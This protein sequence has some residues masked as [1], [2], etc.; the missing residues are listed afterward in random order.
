[1][2]APLSQQGIGLAAV[3]IMVYDRE[4]LPPIQPKRNWPLLNRRK[5]Y[6]HPLEKNRDAE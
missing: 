3:S 1:M 4:F 6:P 5:M 2:G